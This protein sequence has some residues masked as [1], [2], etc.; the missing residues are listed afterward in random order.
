MT[1][2]LH[3]PTDRQHLVDTGGSEGG[4]WG[5][6]PPFKSLAPCT[7][8]SNAKYYTKCFPVL[9]CK[10]ITAELQYRFSDEAGTCIMTGVTVFSTNWTLI[11]Y[12]GLR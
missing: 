1:S 2:F 10:I 11:R 6:G 5:R 3:R 8:P 7:P 4:Q 12:P 9:D